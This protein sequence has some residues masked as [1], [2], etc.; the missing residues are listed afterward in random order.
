[1]TD[2]LCFFLP[3]GMQGRTKMLKKGKYIVGIIALLLYVPYVQ[4]EIVLF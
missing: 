4:T 1:M 2:D 3:E